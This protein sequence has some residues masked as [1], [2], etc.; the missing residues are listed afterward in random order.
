MDTL[1]LWYFF[2]GEDAF[3]SATISRDAIV[4]EVRDEI[5]KQCSKSYCKDVDRRRLRLLKVFHS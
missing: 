3:K 4:A 2:E 1:R 5:H